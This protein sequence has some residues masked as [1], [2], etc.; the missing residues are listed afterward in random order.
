LVFFAG[1]GEREPLGNEALQILGVCA[2][3]FLGGF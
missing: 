3:E 1:L 2:K